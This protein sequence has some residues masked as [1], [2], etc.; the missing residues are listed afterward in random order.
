VLLR[1]APRTDRLDEVLLR[2]EDV[3]MALP[4]CYA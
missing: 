1:V 2:F 4:V 3:D